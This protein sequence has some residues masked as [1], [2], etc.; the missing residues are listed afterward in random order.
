MR[1]LFQVVSALLA[2][3][4]RSWRDYGESS[5]TQNGAGFSV[6][7]LSSATHH[8]PV[9]NIRPFSRIHRE[10]VYPPR[11]FHR[12]K[13]LMVILIERASRCYEFSFF[14]NPMVSRSRSSSG[15]RLV[16]M[17]NTQKSSGPRLRALRKRGTLR[18]RQV[19]RLLL[20][21]ASPGSG[22]SL[23]ACAPQVG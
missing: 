16:P 17:T 7:I 6:S 3:S 10:G 19:R 1:I 13:H 20:V 9:L 14:T 21:P 22:R 18:V 8:N 2:A 11:A 12:S 4:W 23:G 5:E 15:M